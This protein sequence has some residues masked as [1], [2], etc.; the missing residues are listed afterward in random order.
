MFSL[1][2]STLF[3]AFLLVLLLL[4][5]NVSHA[6]GPEGTIPTGTTVQADAFLTAP[7]VI[8]DGNVEGDLF[9]VG[10]NVTLNG[11][12]TGSVF[13]IAN[14]ATLR[15]QIGG[16]VYALAANLNL[17]ETAQI[18]HS[19]YVSALSLLTAKGSTVERDLFT[20]S[21]GAQLSGNVARMT[22]AIIG[23]VEIFRLLMTQTESLRLFSTSWH[24][25]PQARDTAYSSPRQTDSGC[26]LSSGVAMGAAAGFVGN[27]L[28]C[29]LNPPQRTLSQAEEQQTDTASNARVWASNRAREFIVLALIGLILVF[30][31]P[32]LLNEWSVP[33]VTRPWLAGLVGLL[34]A[35]NG[36]ILGVL[37][38]LATIALGIL[39]LQL[40]LGALTFITWTLGLS[41]TAAAFWLFVLFLFYISQIVFATWAANWA[42]KRLAPQ[43]KLHPAIPMLV[44]VLLLVVL[45]ALPIVGAFISLLAAFLGMGGIVLTWM[46]RYVAKRARP[47]A[48]AAV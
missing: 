47:A 27:A 19:V 17:D 3:L 36:F 7:D 1:R 32:R 35:V 6:Q 30:A 45:A 13:L 5:S 29:L 41:L 22:R 8:V 15:G 2:R 11:N 40:T 25:A 33:I 31:F 16:S 4:G 23:P 18:N 14:R 39:F 43:T 24:I 48:M 21:V 10:E 28:D 42:L 34:V 20:I 46:D 9:A 26:R 38:F 37:I 44:G 12:V